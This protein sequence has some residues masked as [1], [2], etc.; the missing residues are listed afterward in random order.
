MD[1]EVF[2][3]TRIKEEWDRTNDNTAAVALG[4]ARTGRVI[5]SA[6]L[7]MVVI[8]GT[9]ALGDLI[10]SKLVGLGLAI[11]I[12]LDATVVRLILA[13]A[14]MRVLGKWNWWAPSFLSR[15]WQSREK[16]G[17][18]EPGRLFPDLVVASQGDDA[19]RS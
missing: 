8:F 19:R 2:L 17:S 15:H 13:P 7:L 5:T 6:A 9:F 18:K 4:L 3:L 12:L 14:L 16:A 11:A 10:L 1:Y